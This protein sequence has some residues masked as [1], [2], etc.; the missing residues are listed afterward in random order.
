MNKNERSRWRREIKGDFKKGL[1]PSFV[2]ILQVY[3]PIEFCR[4]SRRPYFPFFFFVIFSRQMSFYERTKRKTKKQTTTTTRKKKLRSW[5]FS[6]G[7][8]PSL[9][10]RRSNHPKLMQTR[11]CNPLLYVLWRLRI[12]LFTSQTYIYISRR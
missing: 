10:P 4:N 6:K 5:G 11:K 7:G 3:K 12:C 8:L 9:K 2:P 1:S